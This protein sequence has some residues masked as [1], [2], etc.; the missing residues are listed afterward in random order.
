MP[1]LFRVTALQG[2]LAVFLMCSFS[3]AQDVDKKESAKDLAAE[4][5]DQYL[6]EMEELA[7]WGYFFSGDVTQVL[8]Q[9]KFSGS[10]PYIGFQS[11]QLQDSSGKTRERFWQ[12]NSRT[13]DPTMFSGVG[14][15]EL[16]IGEDRWFSLAGGQIKKYEPKK[17]RK[18]E[19][20]FMTLDPRTAVLHFAGAVTSGLTSDREFKKY[21]NR[22]TLTNAEKK[23]GGI[24]AVFSINETWIH[25]FFNES[26]G[27]MPTRMAATSEGQE[28]SRDLT[29]ARH[30]ARM[31]WKKMNTG[32]WA[33]E[34]GENISYFGGNA[35]DY[36]KIK[37][38]NYRVV[39]IPKSEL[40]KN[41]FDKDSLSSLPGI[42]ME[43]S[44]SWM[45]TAEKIK[46]LSDVDQL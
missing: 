20:K 3:M 17:D 25:V 8:S 41:A 12:V 2:V 40:P 24:D 1:K 4:K 31:R 18:F 9:Q 43:R 11:M 45:K 15:D 6:I 44:K 33:P 34:Y 42:I 26:Q 21:I 14:Y 37:R 27:Y 32:I 7:D 23:L 28:L 10:F 39:W 35:S 30:V 16:L 29:N 19:R 22:R 38:V 13:T 36:T 46:P 5:L